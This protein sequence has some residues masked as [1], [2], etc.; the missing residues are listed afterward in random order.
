MKTDRAYYIYITTNI[1]N[2][3]LYIGITNNLPKRIYEHKNGLVKG[4]SKKY[5]V[6]KLV[7]Y[8]NTNDV[9]SAIARKKQLKNWHREWKMN[10][11]EAKNPGFVE[12]F[13]S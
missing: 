4:F 5:K 7:Y 1:T 9:N 2:N 10:L 3:V 12:L 8:E 13:I 11:V 6:N